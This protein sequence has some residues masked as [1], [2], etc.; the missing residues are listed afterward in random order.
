LFKKI[1]FVT[2]FYEVVVH[3]FKSKFLKGGPINGENPMPIELPI[4]SLGL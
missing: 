2:E 4:S 1:L 3:C